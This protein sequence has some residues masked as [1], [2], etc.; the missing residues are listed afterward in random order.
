MVAG[1]IP[2]RTDTMPIAI[3]SKVGS[4]DWSKAH[5]MVIIFTVL[6][7]LVLYTSNKLSKRIF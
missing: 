4:G 6:S 7:G 5:L 1:N 2:G 3:Y